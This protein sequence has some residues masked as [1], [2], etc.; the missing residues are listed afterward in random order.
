LKRFG[1]H[2]LLR[3]NNAL[4]KI[5]ERKALEKLVTSSIK[6]EKLF[7]LSWQTHMFSNI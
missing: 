7:R 2:T 5:L 4:S 6:R 1:C 3:H